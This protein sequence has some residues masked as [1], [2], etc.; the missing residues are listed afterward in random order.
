MREHFDFAV[1]G[2]G[3]AGALS[4]LSWLQTPVLCC[5]I[6]S[7]SRATTPPEDQ[8]PIFL[9]PMEV[10]PFVPPPPPVNPSRSPLKGSPN[11]PVEVTRYV[12]CCKTKPAA[13]AQRLQGGD[14]RAKEISGSDAIL[15]VPILDADSVAAGILETGGEILMWM[16]RCRGFFACCI[17]EAVLCTVSR[18]CRL[19]RNDQAAGL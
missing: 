16:P 10:P 14:L 9:L 18:M 3:I 7:L 8:L 2:A 19:Y 4:Q 5:S 17:S 11:T 13:S 12:V 6:R 1:I 15:R